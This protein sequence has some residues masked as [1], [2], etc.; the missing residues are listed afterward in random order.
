MLK[1]IVFDYGK[2]LTVPPTAADW[3]RLA[4]VFGVPVERF[5]KPY[6]E[7]R[8]RYDRATF[9]AETYWGGVASDLGKEISEE[10]VARLVVLDNTQ[11]TRENPEML[12]FAWQVQD[13]GLKIGILSN[14]QSDMLKAM[15]QKLPWL[16]RFDAQV[17]TCEVG[18]I[19]P[20]PE[21][22][23]AIL[24]ELDVPARNVLF[25]DDKQPNIDGARAVGMH[26]EIFE[27]DMAPVYA[28]AA[29]LGLSLEMR[30]A[31]D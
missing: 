19:K 14:M 7:L 26:A 11:W 2:V 13:A 29:R 23:H 22:Y 31:A 9:T 27:G 17:Y 6:W 10:D 18:V 20:E 15:R 5:Q 30:K 16:A 24:H 8:D 12:E 21:S 25:L 4:G 3:E 28:A 1:A